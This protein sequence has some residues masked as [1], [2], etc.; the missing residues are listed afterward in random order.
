MT[1]F[2]LSEREFSET[3]WFALK[4]WEGAVLRRVTVFPTELHVG[5]GDVGEGGG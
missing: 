1:S 2:K 5:E 4:R 3:H